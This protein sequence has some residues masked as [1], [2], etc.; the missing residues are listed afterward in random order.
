MVKFRTHEEM[1]EVYQGFAKRG[2]RS[3]PYLL[4]YTNN[5]QILIFFGCKHSTDLADSQ[6]PVL[7]A[8]WTAFATND[9]DKKVLIY[10]RQD[11]DIKDETRDSALAKYSESGL[12]VWLAVQSEVLY[13]SGE[14]QM[15]AEIEHLKKRFSIPEIV[16]YYFA[17]QMLQWLTRDSQMEPDWRIYATNTLNKYATLGCW[18]NAKLE[19]EVVLDWFKTV[20]GKEFDSKDRQTLYNLS[21]P[22]QSKISS[23]SG[24]F[25]DEHLF[26][27][28]KAKWQ[29]GYDVF[30]V[31]GT[32]HAIVLEP[33]L[34]KLSNS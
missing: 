27:K 14:P 26:Q 20:Y 31:Y 12:A 18:E 5:H 23:A 34:R 29:A 4:E 11:F 6:W 33:A 1:D 16:T 3:W 28:I 19:L 32:G 13:V 2:E 15:I 30:V 25:R 9:N 7:E 10:E 22:S 24:V 21:D 8:K 17:R